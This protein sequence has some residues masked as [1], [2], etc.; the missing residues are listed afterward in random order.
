MKP[1]SSKSD[2]SRWKRFARQFL[3]LGIGEERDYLVEN[4][5]L[6]LSAGLDVK[7][8]L[9]AIRQGVVSRRLQTIIHEVTQEI[10][11]GA[12]LSSALEQTE[13]VAVQII[14]LIRIGERSG[15]LSENLR[16]I[17]EQYKKDREFR[18]KV[19]SAM[20]YPILVL[21]I[22]AVLGLGIAWLVLPRLVNVFH[23]LTI[24]L[25]MITRI[26]LAVGTFLGAHGHI[27]V[28]LIGL[29]ILMIIYIVFLFPP[30]KRIGQAL[31]F[32]IPGIR[33]L[34]REVELA[35]FGYVLGT[36]L[37]AGVPIMQS[38]EALSDSTAFFKYKKLFRHLLEHV[39]LGD[40][41][42]K[43]FLSF[44]SLKALIPPPIQQMIISGEESGRLAEILII[45]GETFEHRTETTTKNLVVVLE[46]ILLALV[47]AAVLLV[48]LAIIMPIYSL[49]GNFNV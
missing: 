10:S 38:L 29:G 22:A 19:R 37:S 35:R 25:P 4:L 33:K 21:S 5:S 9:E 34:I 47:S 12:P 16:V 32:S 20:M 46:P 27:F 49:I 40:S 14:A 7:V 8:A 18:S 48:A 23:S 36:L 17:G 11:A 43:S 2:R 15:R 24:E 28:P 31:L 6:L 1:S 45:I 44:R 30:T 41:F 39:K 13:L 42:Q 26:L 3:N